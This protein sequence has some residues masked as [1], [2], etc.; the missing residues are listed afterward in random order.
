MK[1]K[2]GITNRFDLPGAVQT[3]WHE[4]EG[5]EGEAGEGE[6][7]EEGRGGTVIWDPFIR[8]SPVN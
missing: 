7:E 1:R 4:E 8:S 2:S 6:E 5:E 3:G